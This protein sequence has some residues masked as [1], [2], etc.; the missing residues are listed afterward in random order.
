[1]VLD[2]IKVHSPCLQ[3]MVY[4]TRSVSRE[5]MRTKKRER[6]C[7]LK[8]EN[9]GTPEKCTYDARTCVTAY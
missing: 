6:M 9:I 1:M 8:I 3:R 2:L 4:E 7:S 5:R